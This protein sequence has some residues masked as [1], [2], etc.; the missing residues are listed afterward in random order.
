MKKKKVK[1]DVCRG[2]VMSSKTL[3]LSRICSEHD[4]GEPLWF[5]HPYGTKRHDGTAV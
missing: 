3:S 1:K 4:D 5:N 2:T